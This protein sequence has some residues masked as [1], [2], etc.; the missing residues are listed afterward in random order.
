VGQAIGESLP[1][2]VG[3]ALSPIAIVAVVLMLESRHGRVNAPAFVL[4]W[5]A[6]LAI[7]GAIVLVVGSGANASTRGK[8]ADWVSW[9]KLALGLGLLVLSARQW[10][11][12]PSDPSEIVTPKWMGALDTFTPR[13]AIAVGAALAAVNPKN[14][15]LLVAGAAAVAQTGISTGQQIAAWAVFCAIATVGVGAPVIA[16]VA[17]GD[18]SQRFLDE[19]KD[20]MAENNAAVIATLLLVFGWKLIG[21]AISGLT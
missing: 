19:L 5:V 1:A 15:L 8:P 16:Y 14:L 2:A 6:G 11:A 13:R 12:R 18:R 21:D 17:G 7:V 20:W 10:R 3:I 4:G 9:L